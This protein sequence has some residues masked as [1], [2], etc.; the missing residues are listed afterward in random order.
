MSCFFETAAKVSAFHIHYTAI[1]EA[2][3]LKQNQNQYYCTSQRYENKHIAYMQK[4]I[5]IIEYI[6]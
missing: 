6:V 5:D 4:S 2:I 1:H 3:K